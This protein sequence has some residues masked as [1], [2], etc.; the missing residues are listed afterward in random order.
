MSTLKTHNLQSSDSGSVNIAL[1]PNAGM[2]VT[3]ITTIS[4]HFFLQ[5]DGAYIDFKQTDGTQTGYIQSRTTDFRF[6][7]YGARPVT[8]G[9]NDVERVRITSDGDVGVGTATPI[10]SSG[11]GNLS[12]VGSNGGQVELKRLSGDV[13]HYIWGET[14]LNIGA[15]YI[16]GGFILAFTEIFILKYLIINNRHLKRKSP[17]SF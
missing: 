11:Y 9:T 1:A 7:S 3:G 14:N 2:V 5:K 8:F 13:R 17:N 16:N 4:N 15:G 12:L 10:T 6:N